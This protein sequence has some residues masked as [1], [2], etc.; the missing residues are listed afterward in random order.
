MPCGRI[1]LC[2]GNRGAGTFHAE[3]AYV[4]EFVGTVDGLYIV[5]LSVGIDDDSACGP[6]KWF[7]GAH[8]FSVAACKD[9]MSGADD[10]AVGSKGCECKHAFACFLYG[11][12]L[13]LCGYGDGRYGKEYD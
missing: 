7:P 6:D 9:A 10:R 4:I 11:C 13:A 8:G 5:L 12:G 2:Q 3:A 1:F